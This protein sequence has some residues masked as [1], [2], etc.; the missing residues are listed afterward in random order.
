[1]TFPYPLSKTTSILAFFIK[2]FPKMR[3]I[4]GS[5]LKS[6]ITKSTGNEK[7]FVCISTS[8][9]APT[10]FLHVFYAI[11]SSFAYDSICRYPI[12]YTTG[13]GIILTFSPKSISAFPIFILHINICNTTTLGSTYFLGRYFWSSMQA[14]SCNIFSF[15][16]YLDLTTTLLSLI[17]TL[18]FSCGLFFVYAPNVLLRRY[19]NY[20]ANWPTCILRFLM[21]ASVLMWLTTDTCIN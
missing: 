9:I 18:H 20:L 1:M 17:T 8:L 12:L 7:L 21:E 2:D 19:E 5:A 10:S 4:F 3:G 6:S 15:G 14:S 11:C 16:L 13:S